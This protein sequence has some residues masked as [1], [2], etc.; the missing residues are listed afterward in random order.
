MKVLAGIFMSCALMVVFPALAIGQMEELKNSTPQ[1]RATLQTEWMK[2]TLSLDAK[3]STAVDGINLRY[4]QENQTLIDSSGPKLG[5]F[6]TFRK[7]FSATEAELK[8]ILTP[9]Q[10][11]LYEEKKAEMEEKVKQKIMAKHQGA[12]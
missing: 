11:G 4:A 6:M 1:E 5:K 9:Q 8:A 3:A 7:N 2:T 12:Q 10:Y